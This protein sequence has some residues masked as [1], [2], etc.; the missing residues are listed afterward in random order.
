MMWRRYETCYGCRAL[1]D[2]SADGKLDYRCGLGYSTLW[3]FSE[4]VP[5][6]ECDKPMTKADLMFA[7][8]RSDKLSAIQRVEKIEKLKSQTKPRVSTHNK[9]G[10]IKCYHCN[11]VFEISMPQHGRASF[12]KTKKCIHCKTENYILD[13]DNGGINQGLSRLDAKEA[14]QREFGFN[15]LL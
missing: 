6:E 15:L 13:Y 11:E 3:T 10:K 9:L 2:F 5:T 12:P 1:E 4:L 7:Y 8:K 14:F